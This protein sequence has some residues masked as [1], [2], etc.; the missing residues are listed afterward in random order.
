MKIA[1]LSMVLSLPLAAQ[2]KTPTITDAQKAAFWKAQ[3]QLQADSSAANAAQEKLNKTRGA[4]EAAVK[5]LN[6]TCG[7]D[8]HAQM[9]SNGDPT[10][11]ANPKPTEA[12]KK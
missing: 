7:K 3:A 8:F 1:I 12:P 2:T 9:D 5:A 4:F 6:D 11:V 10:C